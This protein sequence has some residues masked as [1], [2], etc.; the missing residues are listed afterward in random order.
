M[1]GGFFSAK[2]LFKWP[3]ELE[4]LGWKI[5]VF[6]GEDCPTEKKM[7]VTLPDQEENVL[8]LFGKHQKRIEKHNYWSHKMMETPN[9]WN[10]FM[11]ANWKIETNTFETTTRWKFDDW[12]KNDGKQHLWTKIHKN[13]M[14]MNH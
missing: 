13:D 5:S 3:T 8:R 11:E 14:D 6:E 12:L 9:D 4:V 7:Q 1:K 10:T 2:R